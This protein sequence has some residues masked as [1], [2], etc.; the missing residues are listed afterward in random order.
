MQVGAAEEHMQETSLSFR[1]TGA[2]G[3]REGG[4]ASPIDAIQ[5][6]VRSRQIG[7]GAAMGGSGGR[8]EAE[9][10]VTRFPAGS[11]GDRRATAI[12]FSERR[13]ASSELDV[14]GVRRAGG[15]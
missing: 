14:T 1:P 13:K 4:Y 8:G 9:A 2:A 15:T 6:Y 3:G 10:R 7:G 12:I 11:F 5:L